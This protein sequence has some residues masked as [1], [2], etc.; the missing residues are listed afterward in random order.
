MKTTDDHLR[1]KSRNMNRD[2]STELVS[3]LL[4][5]T[6]NVTIFLL[7][8]SIVRARTNIKAVSTTY[9]IAR[10]KE[11]RRISKLSS[12]E[13]FQGTMQSF[14]KSQYSDLLDISSILF[15]Y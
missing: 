8:F 15:T 12:T 9:A 13:I 7:I 4:V 2:S 1:N 10:I 11:G 6:S 3:A 14:T 5:G